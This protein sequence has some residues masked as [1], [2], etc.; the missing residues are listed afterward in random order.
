MQRMNTME[1]QTA[2]SNFYRKQSAEALRSIAKQPY[3]SKFRVDA[4]P[5][6]SGIVLRIFDQDGVQKAGVQI[7]TAGV[8]AVIKDFVEMRKLLRD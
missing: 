3:D 4:L 5:D 8:D 2:L 1:G 7:A 6:L